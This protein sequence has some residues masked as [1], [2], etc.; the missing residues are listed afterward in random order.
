MPSTREGEGKVKKSV[1]VLALVLFALAA[2]PQANAATRREAGK[3]PHKVDRQ[4]SDVPP[5]PVAAEPAVEPTK[6]AGRT[7]S[8]TAEFCEAA[9]CGSLPTGTA[10]TVNPY[11]GSESITCKAIK[12]VNNETCAARCLCNHKERLKKCNGGRSCEQTQEADYRACI[13]QCFIDFP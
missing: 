11:E 1:L 3:A 5:V 4:M 10:G 12:R 6:T 2:I 7:G 9:D 8:P 13:Y